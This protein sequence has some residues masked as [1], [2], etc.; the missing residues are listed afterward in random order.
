MRICSGIK[1]EV[2]TGASASAASGNWW[3]SRRQGG[4]ELFNLEDDRTEFN[5]LA[6]RRPDKMKELA[7]KYD[8]WAERVGVVPWE[9]FSSR[10]AALQK[11]K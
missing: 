3:V 7:A 4:W 1:G 6:D 8:A 2:T 9:V 5:N 11:A 10:K